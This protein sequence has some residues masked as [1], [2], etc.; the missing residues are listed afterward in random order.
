MITSNNALIHV[1]QAG[2]RTGA[3]MNPWANLV[4]D[5]SKFDL[6]SEEPLPL[7]HSNLMFITND[8]ALLF[9]RDGR[10]RAVKVQRDGRTISKIE[11]LKDHLEK[12]V[13]PSS[14][15][16]IRSHFSPR[17]ADGTTQACYAFVGSLLGD[18][19]L[20]KVDFR[21]IVDEAL[22]QQMPSD[23]AKLEEAAIMDED[24]EDDIGELSDFD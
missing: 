3:S 14:I 17:G 11:L 16:L 4:S 1:D 8:V 7:E 9:I 2:K 19:Q 23:V 5:S 13:P 20:L 21:T 18:S 15:E 22:L 24:D 10:L 6:V 12:T